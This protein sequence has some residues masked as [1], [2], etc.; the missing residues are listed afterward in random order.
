MT[1]RQTERQTGPGQT[2]RIEHV[3]IVGGG[4]AGWLSAVFLNRLLAREGGCRITLIE[5][6]ALG[7]LG[8]GEATIPTLRR[9]F[10]LCGIDETDWMVRCNAS[11]KLAI[12]FV[13]WTGLPHRP[14]YW[15][16][17]GSLPTADGLSLTQ[18]WL[19]RRLGGDPTPL[20]RAC[21][22]VLPA[23]EA[24]LAPKQGGEPEYEGQVTY[25]Y[26]LDAGRLASYLASLGRARGVEHVVDEVTGVSLDGRGFVRALHTARHG[27]LGGDLFLDCSGFA[28][29]LINRA[30]GEPFVSYADELP[31]DRAVALPLPT[32]DAREGIRPYTTATALG[33][34]W[35]WNT[36]LFG[37]S[38]N[39]YVYSSAFLTP[40]EAEREFRAHLGP[41][42]EG[43]EARHLRM[44]VGHTRRPWVGNCV[45][46][47]L[48]GGF[49][50]P[51]EST[52]IWFIELGLYNLLLNF[53]DK[54][55]APAVAEQYNRVMARYYEHVRDF[56]VLHYCLTRR[57]DTPFWR[58]NRERRVPDSL[59]GQ[60]DLWRE[61]LPNH[62][63]LEE[64]GLFKDVNYAYIL[65]GMERLPAHPLPL[66][67]YGGDRAAQEAFAGVRREAGRLRAVLP[68]H[69]RYLL[70]LRQGE[71]AVGAGARPAVR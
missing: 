7:T 47:G 16:P 35:V 52:G 29:L 25:A 51:L 6:S 49:V 54:R 20:D 48:A 17:F 13:N 36:P 31:C 30:L 10:A 9:T 37:R 19:A 33:S 14:V 43:V 26:H 21:A 71:A 40:E 34:G 59:R 55:F 2:G 8:V 24:R 60:L 5:S 68:D 3:V 23:C 63:K 66:L 64:W 61:L 65:A 50:E 45:A 53:P 38:G 27:D 28:G 39:G 62:Q 56:I 32:D 57:E 4:T 12:R 70:G 42:S 44:R 67:T 46:I 22:S 15:H 1:E 58:A 69:Y 18:H 41:A 11:F